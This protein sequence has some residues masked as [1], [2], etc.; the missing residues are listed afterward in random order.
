[1]SFISKK[2]CK[3]HNAVLIRGIRGLAGAYSSLWTKYGLIQTNEFI[4]FESKLPTNLFE[5][6]MDVDQETWSHRKK[7]LQGC[8]EC[9]VCVPATFDHAWGSYV[10]RMG[11]R[12]KAREKGSW[13]DVSIIGKHCFSYLW[14]VYL[15]PL[16][17]ITVFLKIYSISL[18]YRQINCL[19]VI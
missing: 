5:E 6:N 8:S 14:T 15:Y 2:L 3:T 1:M 17:H 13:S 10:P 12:G 11:W 16:S 18:F 9:T 7:D 4:A 19:P